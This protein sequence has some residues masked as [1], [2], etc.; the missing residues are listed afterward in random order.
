M[1]FMDVSGRVEEALKESWR[2][3]P[4]AMRHGKHGPSNQDYRQGK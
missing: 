2:Q 1:A 4:D 3:Q